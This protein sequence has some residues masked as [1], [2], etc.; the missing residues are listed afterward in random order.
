MLGSLHHVV[1][2]LRLALA[3]LVLAGAGASMPASALPNAQAAVVV[4]QQG[5]PGRYRAAAHT[6]PKHQPALTVGRMFSPAPTSF[7]GRVRE[8]EP[9]RPPQRL[10]IAHRALLH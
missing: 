5:V 4:V 3:C 9:P 2:W 6:V 1:R 7:A 8:A 10:F